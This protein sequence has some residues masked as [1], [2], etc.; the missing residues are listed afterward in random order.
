[1]AHYAGRDPPVGSTFN[2]RQYVYSSASCMHT[3]SSTQ[4]VSGLLLRGFRSFLTIVP[5]LEGHQ[6]RQPYLVGPLPGRHDHV[7]LSAE[8]SYEGRAP[9][10]MPNLRE[11]VVHVSGPYR[12]D[13]S[14]A[15]PSYEGR[16]PLLLRRTFVRG[17]CAPWVLTGSILFQP[18]LH[19]RVVLVPGS[20][21][22][23]F[24]SCRTF[25]RRS[26]ASFY[27]KLHCTT[28]YRK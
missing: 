19:K 28:L 11:R 12:L 18:N 27:T 8:P 9:L 3:T 4:N 2:S 26:C 7:F 16:A 23:R 17:S 13:F 1:M 6:T 5:S 15:E 10:F 24:C 25:I 21:Q 22:A 14:L 20:F